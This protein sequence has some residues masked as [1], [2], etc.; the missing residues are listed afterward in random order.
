MYPSPTA[1]SFQFYDSPIKSQFWE[2][3]SH[4]AEMFQFYD[5]PIKSPRTFFYDNYIFVFQFYDSPIKSTSIV[6]KIHY[7]LIVSILW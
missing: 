7:T 3:L 1:L 6:Q 2:R 5:S 4:D